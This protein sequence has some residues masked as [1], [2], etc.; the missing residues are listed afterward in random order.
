MVSSV[1]TGDRLPVDEVLPEL[2][3]ALKRQRLVILQAPPG[4]GKTTRV[5]PS[6]VG[7]PWMSHTKV[8]VLEP[9]RVAARAAA[10]RMASERGEKIGQSIGLRTRFDTRV[11]KATQVEVVTEGV[12]TRMLLNDPGLSG[13][14][15]V[16]FDEFHERSIHADTALAFV[17]ET[18]DALR[19]DLRVIV[20]SATLDAAS[21]A[22]RLRSDAIITAEAPLHPVELRYQPP[23]PGVSVDEAVVPTVMELLAQPA[24]DT[25]DILVFMAGAGV[26]NRAERELSRRTGQ[27]VVITPL[28][29][30]LPPEAQDRALQVDSRGRRKV[31]LST[32]IAETSVTID[33]VRTVVDTGRRRRPEIDHGRGMSRLRTTSASQAACDQRTG[34]AGRQ[35]PGLSI[36][37]WT[38]GEHSHR[39]ADEPPEILTSDLTALALQI[40]AW[41]ANEPSD[42][43]WLDAPPTVAIDAARAVLT[44]LDALDAD[45]RLTDH[46]KAIHRLGT[47]PRLAHMLVRAQALEIEGVA[48]ALATACEVA[49]AL[50]DRDLLR[51]RDRPIDLRARVEVLARGTRQRDRGRLNVDDAAVRQAHAVADRW[52]KMLSA[53]LESQAGKADLDLVGLVTS[54]AFPERIA[55]RREDVGSYL[56]ASG[57]GVSSPPS[58]GLA[59]ERWLAVAETS[60]TGGAAEI[61]LAAPISIEEIE[62][63]HGDRISQADTGGWDR[64]SRDVVFESQ[65]RLGAIVVS[66]SPNSDPD[67]HA[68]IDALLAGVRREGLSI[69]TWERA[70]ERYRSRLAFLHTIDGEEWPAVTDDA[71]L[72]RLDDWLAPALS[73]A[74][75]RTDVERLKPREAL[76]NLI[77]WRHA[78][79]LD[80]L[81]PTHIEVPSG[82]RLPVDYDGQGGPSLPVRLQEVFGL[83]Q[84]PTVADGRVAITLELLSPAHRPV[85][86]TSDL[87]GF[88]ATSYNEVRKEMRGRYPKHHWPEDP[89]TAAATNRTKR[90]S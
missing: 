87:A 29:G 83:D 4:T 16:I 13:Y 31:I 56:L 49:A 51:G 76:A 35:G 36:R 42:L 66:R 41:G 21:L 85:Q 50:S 46:G 6:I 24:A 88:W 82:S 70:D 30:S 15:A 28:H 89:M 60:G 43:P 20:M 39:R 12:L 47:E 62:G 9:R 1:P 59:R 23:L 69:L 25:G 45:G 74:K 22:T 54:F 77:D 18:S 33:G 63:H 27:D 5:P 32:P 37:L 86:I 64:R 19:D 34:R 57:A 58:D 61:R 40:A 78:R 75:R 48:G 17:R 73:S 11:S 38:E 3:A 2:H 71:L 44:D 65:Q 7:Q 26:I 55:Q 72:D 14:G 10:R 53:D 80:R 8:I 68:V 90:R 52:K 67:R 81:A 84:S 79:D